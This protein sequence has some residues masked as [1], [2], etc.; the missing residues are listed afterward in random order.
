MSLYNACM[1]CLN[2]TSAFWTIQLI[3]KWYSP[4]NLGKPYTPPNDVHINV[5]ESTRYGYNKQNCSHTIPPW[6]TPPIWTFCHPRKSI[7]CSMSVAMVWV[8]WWNNT[9]SELWSTPLGL[10]INIYNKI[11]CI[12]LDIRY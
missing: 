3:I 4:I 10:N 6:D 5:H 12:I 7:N 2:W 8:V 11:F 1:E 9:V